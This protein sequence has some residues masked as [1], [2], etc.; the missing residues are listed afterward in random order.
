MAG[1]D[2]AATAA[3]LSYLTHHPSAAAA[4][5]SLQH[6]A[7]S[8]YTLTPAVLFHLHSPPQAKDPRR[9]IRL[10]AITATFLLPSLAALSPSGSHLAHIPATANWAALL[11]A[12]SATTYGTYS[13]LHLNT[14]FS[15]SPETRHI[16]TSGPYRH[17]RHPLY[18]A[19][20]V[21]AAAV[22]IGSLEPT[23]IVGAAALTALQILRIHA[24]EQLLST[25]PA[26][27]QLQTA[28]AHRLIPG[29]W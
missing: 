3:N 26:Y 13:L 14:N 15:L 1:A 28:V 22:A 18:L 21:A 6:L 23:L 4:G 29:I 12:T 24:E 27:Q 2:L 25:Q 7:T 5:N 20:I 17:I 9:H 11:L 16:T 8:A 19:E 10:T